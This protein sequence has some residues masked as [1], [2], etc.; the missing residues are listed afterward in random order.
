MAEKNDIFMVINEPI[1]LNLLSDLNEP[2]SVRIV[3][4]I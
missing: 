4:F 2:F 1:K 3:I